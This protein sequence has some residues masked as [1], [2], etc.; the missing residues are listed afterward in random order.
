[1]P[2]FLK[3]L[4]EMLYLVKMSVKWVSDLSILRTAVYGLE[5]E[6]YNA[7]SSAYAALKMSGQMVLRR[8]AVKMC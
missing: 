8:C 5:F 6:L 3:G 1:M 2:S 4:V 7:M